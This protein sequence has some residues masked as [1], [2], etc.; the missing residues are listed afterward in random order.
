LE[1]WVG[2][3]GW[4]VE[5]VC[6]ELVVYVFAVVVNGFLGFFFGLGLGWGYWGMGYWLGA[7]EAE[8]FLGEVALW[9]EV[10]VLGVH[11]E[12][13]VFGVELLVPV[14]VRHGLGEGGERFKLLLGVVRGWIQ[15]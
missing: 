6:V 3:G 9:D 11:L 13:Y 10:F 12:G 2:G 5:R 15:I 7:R 1:V 4:A 14:W 8:E